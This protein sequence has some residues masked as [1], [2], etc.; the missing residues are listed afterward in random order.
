MVE[1]ES[2]VTCENRG[3]QAAGPRGLAALFRCDPCDR[4]VSSEC[5]LDWPPPWW[6][7]GWRLRPRAIQ[8]RHADVQFWSGW[9]VQAAV[10]Q[11]GEHG[12]HPAVDAGLLGEADLGED[13]A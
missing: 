12:G 4:S 9:A 11:Q 6:A 1:D 10:A 13:R 8:G 5:G 3:S 2:R 7:G